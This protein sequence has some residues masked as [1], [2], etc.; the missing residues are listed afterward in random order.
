MFKI[1]DLEFDSPFILAPMEAVNCASFRLVCKRR[2]AG[3]VFTDMIDADYFMDAVL[4]GGED[5]AVKKYVN[6]QFDETPLCIQIGGGKIKTL[7]ETAKIVSK[8]AQMID[9]NVGCPLPYMLGKKGGVYLM[10]HPNILEKIVKE[11]RD[12]ISIPFSVKIRAGWDFDSKNAVEV[13]LSLE[14][15]GVDA[16]TVHGRTRTQLYKERADWPLVR[17]V[18]ESVSI[19]VILSG[20]V[21]NSY[22]A[23]MAFMHTKCDFI[24]CARGAMNNPS[25]FKSLN[26]YYVDFKEKGLEPSKPLSTYCK[27]KEDVIADFKEFLELYKEREHRYKL[28]EIKDHAIWAVREA[29]NNTL[30]KQDIIQCEDDK[31]VLKV[32]QRSVF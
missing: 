31:S 15:L 19:P 5:F 27:N 11:L 14:K 24:M 18:K 32:V 1:R 9:Y 12:N 13:A 3:I 22:M 10:K 28:S 25:I 21:T 8:Y 29:K 23:H 4:E 30:L 7:V 20:D 6:P 17:K 16:I 2:G 26:E